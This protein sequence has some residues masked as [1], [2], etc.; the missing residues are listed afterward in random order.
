MRPILLV[1][2]LLFASLAAG[3]LPAQD[4]LRTRY[5]VQAYRLDLEVDPAARRL[6]GTVAVAAKIVADNLE[7]LHLDLKPALTV[8]RVRVLEAALD[9]DV[10]L[11]GPE[12]PFR[13]EGEALLCTLPAPAARDAEVRVAV[14]YHGEPRSEGDFDGFH[15]SQTADG[16]PWI[17]T[18]CQGP[19]A[20]SWWPCKASFFHPEDKP[21]RLLANVT[22]PE[23]LYA[24]SNGRLVKRT[25]PRAGVE[26]FHWRH[27]YPLET[28]TVTLNVAPYVVVES[29]LRLPGLE[30][31]V[32]WIY[33]V[34]PEDQEKAALQFQDVPKLLEIYSEAFGPW[35]FPESKFALVQTS[36]W[37]M[38]HSTAVAYGSSFPAWCKKNGVRDR[39]AGPNR[40]FDYILVHEVAH[41]WWGNA[42]SAAEWGHFWIHEGFGTYAEGVYL[43]RTQGRETADRWFASQSRQFGSG[44]SLFRG[45]GKN[46]GQAYTGLIYG[47]GAAVL[48][49]LRHYVADD[50]A[51]W[52]SLRDFNLAFRYGNARTE[53]FQAIL[54][55]NTGREWKR[56]FQE[57]FYGKG[58]PSLA[59]TVSAQGSAIAVDVDNP[60]AEGRS[61]HIPLDLRWKEAGAPKSLRLWLEP[62]RTTQEIPCAA[63]PE[64]LEVADLHRVLGRH[65]VK[66]P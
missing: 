38:E 48:N 53:D 35:P 7:V 24:V 41:E 16:R 54:E 10:P 59:G 1:T 28:Y 65:D 12:I 6:S 37:G 43:E 42:V 44:G 20:H 45:E 26:T 3:S 19:G 63:P 8:D 61:F 21:A 51:W 58:A 64:S 39:Y 66:V 56:F 30:K 52:K 22:V 15:W 25:K 11:A 5:D 34:L 49:T 9:G 29:E 46:S 57:W 13:H 62:G 55:K 4:D 23:G 31:P 36:F 47:K 50:A 33:Y 2:W 14:T 40:F 18:S 27:D 17:G 60:A 32:P